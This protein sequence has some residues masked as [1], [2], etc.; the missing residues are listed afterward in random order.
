MSG[1][2]A[3]PRHMKS[4]LFVLLFVAAGAIAFFAIK[5]PEK[6]EPVPVTPATEKPA[7]KKSDV[8]RD[9]TALVE[10]I[11]G[12]ISAGARSEAALAEEIR[13]FDVLLERH[14]AADPDQLVEIL[15]LKARLYLEVFGDT[16]KFV[17]LLEQMKRDFPRTEVAGQADAIITRVQKQQA[18]EKTRATLVTGAVF[19]DFEVKDLN[20]NP[21]SLAKFRGKVVLV[22]FWAT[23]CGPC[24]EELPNV[25]AAYKKYR[26]KGFEIVG[27]SLDR[28]EAELRSFVVE[29]QMTW[30]QY[31]D[32]KHWDNELAVRYG[33]ASI[34][35][36]YLLDRDGRI[37]GADLRGPALEEALAKILGK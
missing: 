31:F 24:I 14:K 2:I 36:T 33:V 37:I 10:K 12:R 27:I 29:K 28:N 13:E 20:G 17:A 16:E 18:A 15:L 30:P 25:L 7:S 5:A 23:W 6:G 1:R 8:D 11:N 3:I 34:P 22:D 19:P 4:W 35:T 21:L 9:L 26:A 32:G